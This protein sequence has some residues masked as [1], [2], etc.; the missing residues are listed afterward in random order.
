MEL[1]LHAWDLATATG[2][3]YSCS[4][5]VA[6]AVAKA[7]ADTAE[8]YRQYDGFAAEV[9]LDGDASVFDRALAVSGRQPAGR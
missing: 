3:P 6:A 7:V 1:V 5:E 8:M 9:E 2:Q 4:D